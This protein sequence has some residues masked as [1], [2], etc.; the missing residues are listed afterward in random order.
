MG[1]DGLYA[2]Y[3]AD[4]PTI[5]IKATNIDTGGNALVDWQTKQAAGAGLPDVQSVEEGWLSKVMSVSDSFTDLREYGADDISSRWVDWKVAQA[6]DQ[7]GRIIG[8]GTDIGPQGICFNG[9]LLEAAGMP[10]DREGFA[11]LL[12]APTRRGRSSSRWARSTRPRP[13][14]LGTTSP[15]S[16]GTRWSTSSMRVTTPRTASSTS[17]TTPSSRPAGRCCPTRRPP[18]SPAARPS[19]TGA[20]ARPSS[21]ARSRRSSAPAGCSAS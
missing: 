5:K 10:G 16:S 14:R 20:A 13:A 17:R 9:T 8:Y 1:L 6:T 3:E 19:G 12:A 2:Q 4:H 7:Q 11:Q 21:T 15:A 18:A